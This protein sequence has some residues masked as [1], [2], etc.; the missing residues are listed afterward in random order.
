MDRPIFELQQTVQEVLSGWPGTRKAF[1]ALKT[2]CVGCYL[3]RFC[4]LQDVARTYEI[5]EQ[6]L[7]DELEKV[8]RES[9][10]V[11]RNKS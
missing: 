11:S 9:Q 8:N 3:A 6:T 5:A 7:L 1:L 10:T 4:S 2:R